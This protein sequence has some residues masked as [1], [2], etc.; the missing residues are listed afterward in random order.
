M[1]VMSFK[2][3][4]EDIWSV[5]FI[6]KGVFHQQIYSDELTFFFLRRIKGRALC[7]PT[8]KSSFSSSLSVNFI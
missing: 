3:I 2:S 1:L 5:E 8:Y 7:F 4:V 6:I